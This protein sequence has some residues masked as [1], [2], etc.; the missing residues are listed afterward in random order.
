ME[1]YVYVLEDDTGTYYVGSTTDLKRRI[2]QHST[3]HTQTTRKMKSFR[4]VLSQR[5]NSLALARKV[6]RRVKRMK[7]KDYIVKIV[8]DG[9]IEV[10]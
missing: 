2:R 5:Y 1:A 4:L 9:Y 3:G 7:R 10:A 8:A 6:E